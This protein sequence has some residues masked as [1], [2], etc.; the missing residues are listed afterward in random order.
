MTEPFKP[1]ADDK[2]LTIGDLTVEN[3]A[4]RIA[5]YGDIDITRDKLGR[6]HAENLKAV[7][8][9]ICVALAGDAALPD[10]IAA[11]DKPDHVNNPF[12]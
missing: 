7:L 8:D 1:F 11:P 9:A 3:D 6:E 4:D 10:R 5:F 12:Q 2:S